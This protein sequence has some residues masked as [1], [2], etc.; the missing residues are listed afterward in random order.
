M[1]VSALCGDVNVSAGMARFACV[2][3]VRDTGGDE[4][5]STPMLFG[6]FLDGD[7]GSEVRV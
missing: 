5:R 2:K 4:S 3:R 7:V 6:C 1:S